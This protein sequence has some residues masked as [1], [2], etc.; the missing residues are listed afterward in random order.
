MV[1]VF[2]IN[3]IYTIMTIGHNLIY[4]FNV[5]ELEQTNNRFLPNELDRET[6]S[7]ASQMLYFLMSLE[8][9][10]EPSPREDNNCLTLQHTPEKVTRVR[11][12]CLL[13]TL[14]LTRTCDSRIWSS[15]LFKIVHNIFFFF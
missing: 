4:I 9:E 10:N 7:K 5:L 12:N 13:S 3:N 14:Q 11:V 8:V 6:Y 1:A 2:L 15:F